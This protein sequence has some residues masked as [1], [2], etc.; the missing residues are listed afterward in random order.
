MH[1]LDAIPFDYQPHGIII[2]NYFPHQ[3]QEMVN[4]GGQSYRWQ[5]ITT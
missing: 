1:L 5:D 2:C 4:F 3:N